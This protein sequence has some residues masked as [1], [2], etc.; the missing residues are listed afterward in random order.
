MRLIGKKDALVIY[1][2]FKDMFNRYAFYPSI[3]KVLNLSNC[4]II[5]WYPDYTTV[6]SVG[7]NS[8]IGV[9]TNSL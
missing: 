9:I 4:F 5:F 3:I 8:T 6:S 1:L 7:R 2:T